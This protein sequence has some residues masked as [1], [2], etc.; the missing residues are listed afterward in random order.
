MRAKCEKEKEG[1]S[2]TGG[3]KKG[4]NVAAHTRHIVLGSAPPPRDRD[5]P[6]SNC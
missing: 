6:V 2:V 5:C 1:H 4:V 3:S